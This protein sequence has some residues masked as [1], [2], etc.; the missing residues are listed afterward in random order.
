[1][2]MPAR[3]SGDLWR[4]FAEVSELF[5]DDRVELIAGRIVVSPL[6]GRRHCEAEFQMWRL[7]FPVAEERGWQ[8]W[9]DME[10]FFGPQRDR[11]RP[12][13]LVV[14]PKPRMWT[15]NNI[16][17]DSIIMVVEV[18][19]PRSGHD[20]HE[21]KPAE[22]GRGGVQL[23]LVVDTIAGV[24]RLLSEPAQDGY[25]K[26]TEIR[27]G[28]SLDLPEPFGVTLDTTRLIPPTPALA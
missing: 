24:V 6:P 20:D 1:M 28:E 4:R 7:L 9:H 15:D 25:R 27:L 21:V 5:R 2:A 17:A 13:I 11:Y 8:L 16:C 3:D 23:Y 26:E 18:V 10:V 22:C 14:P 12:D 19:S